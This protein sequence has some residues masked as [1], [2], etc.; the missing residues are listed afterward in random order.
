MKEIFLKPRQRKK[1]ILLKPV[2]VVSERRPRIR[3]LNLWKTSR[4]ANR[5]QSSALK[6]RKRKLPKWWRV[7]ENT[8]HNVVLDSTVLVSAFLAKTG[9]SAGL[10]CKAKD[11]VFDMYLWIKEGQTL[12]TELSIVSPEFAEFRIHAEFPV[13]L[14]SWIRSLVIL[15]NKT[16]LS[17]PNP[18]YFLIC[19]ANLL[20]ISVCLGTGCFLPVEG[21]I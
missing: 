18:K 6:N 11:G 21:F 7:L 20:S 3:F 14:I 9:V 2:T 15:S 8:M 12:K 10:L 4:G 5:N 13:S 19:F 17:Y 16:L 1:G